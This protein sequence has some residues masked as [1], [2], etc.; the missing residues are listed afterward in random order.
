MFSSDC[1]IKNLNSKFTFKPDHRGAI[2]RRN[3]A[4]HYPGIVRY[5]SILIAAT[6]RLPVLTGRFSHNMETL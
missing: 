1:S 4:R 5:V 2:L 6:I 3:P